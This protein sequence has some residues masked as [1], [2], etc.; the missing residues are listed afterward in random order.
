MNIIF[1]KKHYNNKTSAIKRVTP[2]PEIKN[3]NF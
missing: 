2:P 1:N 3:Y